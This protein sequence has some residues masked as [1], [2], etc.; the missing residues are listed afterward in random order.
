MSRLVLKHMEVIYDRENDVLRYDRKLKDGSGTNTYGLEVCKSLSLPNDFMENAHAIR[1]KYNPETASILSFK[2]SHFNAKKIM[3]LCEKC[4]KT[5]GTEVHHLQHQTNADQNGF[6]TQTDGSKIH[7]NKLANLMT[8]CEKCHLSM[9][10][11]KAGH[12]RIRS[13]DGYSLSQL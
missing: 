9:H 13:N 5:I 11:S 4:N 10:T 6:I 3:G 1:M 2:S 8:L 12:K 7:K